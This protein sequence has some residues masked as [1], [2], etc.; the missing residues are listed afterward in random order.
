M[1]GSNSEDQLDTMLLFGQG[2][3]CSAVPAAYEKYMRVCWHR[4]YYRRGTTVPTEVCITHL[5]LLLLLLYFFKMGMLYLLCVALWVF[6]GRKQKKN[7]LH[8]ECAPS[9]PSLLQE[10]VMLHLVYKFEGGGKRKAGTAIVWVCTFTVAISAKFITL[11]AFKCF[12]SPRVHTL[13]KAKHSH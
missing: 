2:P 13:I 8:Y 6:A 9:M 3:S 11:V 12:K 5:L 1:P 10:F 7:E 4:S